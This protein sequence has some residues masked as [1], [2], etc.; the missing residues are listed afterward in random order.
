MPHLPNSPVGE[1]GYTVSDLAQPF[2]CDGEA[3]VLEALLPDTCE[4]QQSQP[5]S[6][7][8]N[9]DYWEREAVALRGRLPGCIQRA[10][11]NSA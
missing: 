8:T 5:P 6:S 1:M 11:F 4:K 7:Q 9:R 10:G 2:P 3:A